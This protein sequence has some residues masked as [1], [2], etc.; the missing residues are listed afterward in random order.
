MSSSL[1]WR[2]VP[3]PPADN[4]LSSDLKFKIRDHLFHGDWPY[5]S[6]F[7]IDRDNDYRLIAYL[8]GLAD[9]GVEDAEKLIELINEHKKIEIWAGDDRG[10][11]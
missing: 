3:P 9:C 7:E 4:H 10:P 11:R 5:N 6:G 8:Q 1:H 2:P